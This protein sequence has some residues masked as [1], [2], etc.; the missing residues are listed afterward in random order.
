MTKDKGMTREEAVEMLLQD[1]KV[2]FNEPVF[3]LNVAK[4]MAIRAIKTLK[5]MEE[6]GWKIADLSSES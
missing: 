4:D 5:V 6:R 1:L 2:H 3:G